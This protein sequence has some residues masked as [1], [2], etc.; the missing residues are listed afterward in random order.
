ML[1]AFVVLAAV[2]VVLTVADEKTW[3][4][5]QR[6]QGITKAG[7]V[8]FG[9]KMGSSRIVAAR[10]LQEHGFTYADS[11]RGGLCLSTTYDDNDDVE[12]YL[13]YSWRRG[14]ICVQIKEDVVRGLEWSFVPFAP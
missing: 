10:T 3:I 12:V 4:A 7:D 11:M 1:A 8:P 2:A 6:P 13:D 14:T 5:T 9:V